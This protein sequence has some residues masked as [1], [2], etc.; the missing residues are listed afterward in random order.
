[1]S[2]SIGAVSLHEKAKRLEQAGKDGDVKTLEADTAEFLNEYRSLGAVLD[3]T[4]QVPD[5]I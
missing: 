3:R 5:E 1:M 2:K 4:V